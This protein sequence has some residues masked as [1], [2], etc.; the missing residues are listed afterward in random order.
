MP[1]YN[2][3]HAEAFINQLT[4]NKESVVTFQLFYDPKDGTKRPDLATHF[5]AKLSQAKGAIERA[6]TGMQGVY[7]CLNETD[8]K[9]RH[10][11]NIINIRALFADFDGIAEPTWPILP[12]FVTKRDDTHGHAFWLVQDIDVD[13]FMYL[14]YRIAM[15]CGTDTQVTDPSRVVRLPGTLHLKDPSTPKMYGVTAINNIG[16]KYIKDDIVNG[17]ALSADKQDEYIKWCDSRVSFDT[18]AGYTDNPVYVNNFVKF[19]TEKAEPAVEGSGTQTLIRVTSWA[20]D[21]GISLPYA[22]ELAWLYY[23]PRCV[24]PWH[25]KERDHFDRTIMHAYKYAKNAPGSKTATAVFSEAPDIPPPPPKREAIEVVRSNDRIDRVTAEGLHPMCTGK[26]P[27]YELAQVIDGVI[28]DGFE[29]LHFRKTFYEFDG[30]VW[31]EIA[32]ELVRA[33][34]QRFYSRY[35]PSNTLVNGIYQ[36]LRDLITIE[37]VDFGHWINSNTAANNVVCFKNGLVNL[38]GD[39]VILSDHDPNLFIFNSLTYDYVPGATCPRWIQFLNDIYERDPLLIYMLQEWFGYCLT[40]D[41]TFQR[42]AV[43]M[44]KSRAG[45]GII[46]RVLK[47]MIGENN[48]CA[49]QIAKLNNDSTLSNMS[50]KSLAL[51]PDAHSVHHSKRDDVLSNFKALTGGDD[52]DYHVMYKGSHTSVFKTHVVLSTNNMPEFNDPSGALVNRMM[53][54]KFTKSFA[55]REDYNLESN[56]KKEIE[57]IAQWA[58]QGLKRLRKNGKFTESKNS[59]ETKAF[60]AEDMNPIQMFIE[61]HCVIDAEHFAPINRIYATYLLWC[62]QNMIEHH[63]SRNKFARVLNASNMP[64]EYDRKRVNGERTYGWQG[65]SLKIMQGIEDNANNPS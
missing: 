22:Q 39:D 36:S 53:M 50:T 3:E 46:T 33:K 13:D 23:N 16:R 61:D 49:P 34:C 27:H 30:V 56:L 4:G 44:G 6:E 52:M 11:Q 45:K 1:N 32:E 21:H 28:W 59:L 24:P 10:A 40:S 31:R 26:S 64:I 14:Q 47:L 29:I 15:S 60:V 12:H 48:T 5:N 54:F 18:D 2:S 17:F 9:G 62:K 20:H 8:F 55:G 43:F 57:G 42:F 38:E 58:L 63:L 7:V 65:L 25:E 35:K 19:L 41:V 37:P 51:I